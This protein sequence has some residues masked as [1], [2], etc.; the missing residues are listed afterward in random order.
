[1]AVLTVSF[2]S[3]CLNRFVDFTVLLP[4]EG[5]ALSGIQTEK[6]RKFKTLYL[7][8]GMGGDD[9]VWLHATRVRELSEKYN[10]A[11]ILPSC[12][13]SYY[14]DSG[15]GA[16]YASYIAKE[17]VQYTRKMFPL[18][19][20]REDTFIAGL[21]MG[22][23]GAIYLALKYPETFSKTVGLSS[24][25][26]TN[27]IKHLKPGEADDLGDY[28]YYSRC[29]GSLSEIDAN[30]KSPKSF[31]EKP[32]KKLRPEIYLACGT[33]DFLIE[34]NRSFKELLQQYQWD[35][36]YIESAGAHN[37]DFWNEYIEKSVKWLL[38]E[39]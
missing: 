15:T 18:S 10:L 13:N 30:R 4:I 1:M 26:I 12:E 11:I 27:K 29:F 9:K 7:L 23:F 28:D 21:S 2:G 6:P 8:H 22:G 25:F 37:F 5:P 35:F 31:I 16:Q 34:E 36:Q 19:N 32:T 20:R 17:L 33:E 24:A 38:N 39:K 3:I 14:L